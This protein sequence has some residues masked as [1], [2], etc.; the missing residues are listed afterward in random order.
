MSMVLRC[1][2]VSTQGER[3]KARLLLTTFIVLFA[4]VSCGD[5]DDDDNDDLSCKDIC[6]TDFRCEAQ[7]VDDDFSF[8]KKEGEEPSDEEVDDC[9]AFCEIGN[10]NEDEL[11]CLADN[12]D[13][14]F[15]FFDG[16]IVAGPALQECAPR[17][18]E[19]DCVPE[20]DGCVCT[21]DDD[22]SV[23]EDCADGETE[24]GESCTCT[25]E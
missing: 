5:S 24:D 4:F 9:V 17:D 10:L 1:L 13:C 18:L 8:E 6:Q 12:N 15:G 14:A 2:V 20:D 19:D 21:L 7:E 23:V 25:E 22:D 11:Q 3:M 16:Q